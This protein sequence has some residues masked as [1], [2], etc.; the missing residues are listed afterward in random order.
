MLTGAI[1]VLE[2]SLSLIT[3]RAVAPSAFVTSSICQLLPSNVVEFRKWP[4]NESSET[5]AVLAPIC[6]TMPNGYWPVTTFLL[7][8]F[9]HGAAAG[10]QQ[11]ASEEQ[12]FILLS[13][14]YFHSAPVLTMPVV[15]RKSSMV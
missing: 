13:E 1:P 15:F 10:A 7:Q 4:F 12:V 5:V 2:L 14:Q 11:S 3:I 9:P 8:V 6:G